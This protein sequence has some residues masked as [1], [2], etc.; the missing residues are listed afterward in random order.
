MSDVLLLR[1]DAPLM[2][3]GGTTVD[4][5]NVTE[6]APTLSLLVGLLGNALG[7]DH[8]EAE[9]LQRL[10]D[11]LRFAARRDRQGEE[12]IDY[13]TVDLSQTFLTE[14][15]TTHG[16]PAGR[17]KGAANTGTHIRYRHYWAGAAFTV[18]LRLEPAS[19]EPSLPTIEKAL[20]EPERPLFLG[21]K[22]CLPASPVL[23]GRVDA[24]TLRAALVRAPLAEPAPT[25]DGG[26]SAWWPEDEGPVGATAARLRPVVEERDWANQVHTGRRL[27]WEGR[28]DS[29]EISGE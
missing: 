4:Q 12:L 17:G 16:M 14:S 8:S 20:R 10:Q 19:E 22:T 21:R 1:F 27:I 29:A 5:R 3:F 23:L 28:I 7:Y 2:S 26:Y 18:A 13:Q 11:R 24:P 9:R 25:A 15:W 6:A